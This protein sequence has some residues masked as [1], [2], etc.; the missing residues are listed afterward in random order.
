MAAA[1]HLVLI[2]VV[3]LYR[4]IIIGDAIDDYINGC[5][6]P[7]EVSLMDA[8]RHPSRISVSQKRR[9]S[10]LLTGKLFCPGISHLH[11]DTPAARHG[12][13]PKRSRK[14]AARPTGSMQQHRKSSPSRMI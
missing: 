7:C 1:T 8:G 9:R 6:H 12:T 5:H 2:I 11:Q 14:R 13:F 3:E 10:V 4:P